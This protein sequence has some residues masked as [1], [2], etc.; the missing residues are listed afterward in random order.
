MKKIIYFIVFFLYSGYYAVLALL[1]SFNLVSFSRYITVPLR[2][3]TSGLMVYV[4]LNVGISNNNFFKKKNDLL[5]I[6][7]WNVFF[8]KVLVEFNIGTSLLR[9][10]YEY[11]FYCINFCVLPYFMFSKLNFTKYKDVIL[12]A[13][14][15][16]GFV[17]GCISLFLYRDLLIMGVGRISEAAYLDNKIETISP[18]ALSYCSVLTIA[19]SVYQLLFQKGI[20]LKFKY[21]YYVNIVLSFIMFFLGASRGS[22]IA[23]FFSILIFYFFTNKKVKTKIIKLILIS[24]P[25]IIIGVIKTKSLVFERIFNSSSKVNIDNFGRGDLWRLAFKDFVNNPFFGGHIELIN[26]PGYRDGMAGN[27]YPHNMILEVFMSSGLFIGLLFITVIII[28]FKK[29]FYLVKNNNENI[30]VFII[31]IQSFTQ[32]MF[33]GSIYTAV[34]FF[35]TLGL[36]SAIKFDYKTIY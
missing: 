5:L 1:I 30:W 14:I 27:I 20:N 4:I 16:S 15:F 28:N 3:A 10:W 23:L 13:T 9:S 32:H 12:N 25:L 29:I 26:I 34:L 18:L 8:I 22:V 2:L 36:I 7:I 6:I 21:Y 31:F 19:L 33:T 11:L 35:F 24:I 17:L